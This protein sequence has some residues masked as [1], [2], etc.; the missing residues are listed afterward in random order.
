[1]AISIPMRN[2]ISFQA[3]A[4][5]V[6]ITFVGFAST[7]AVIVEGL[8]KMGAS[9]AEASSGLMAV[10]IAMGL[11]GLI[12]SLLTKMPISVAWSTPGAAL[13][14]SSSALPDGFGGAVGAFM[15]TGALIILA[16]LFKPLGRAVAAIPHPLGNAMLAGVLFGLCLAP[17]KAVAAFPL[18][19]LAI[20]VVWVAVAR[21]KRI[22][23]VPAAV[24]VTVA[25][26]VLNAH[27]GTTG[28]AEFHLASLWP[29]PVV[30]TPSF[31]LA[32]IVGIAIP[33]FLVTMASQNIPG[34]AVL[35]VNGYKP[36]PGKMFAATGILSLLAA[37]FGSHA[38]NLAAI[39]AAL[40]A[41]PDAHPDP[42][43]RYWATATSGALYILVGLMAGAATAFIAA[44]PPL[45]VE[46]VAGLA[47]LGAFGSAVMGAVTAPADREAAVITFVVTAS[48]VGFLG[49]SGA[50]WG[51]I[52]GAVVMALFRWRRVR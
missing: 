36:D 4:T 33:L 1:L 28:A 27:D 11:G 44:S 21:I 22:L 47:L 29:A 3:V 51:L 10:S 7:F 38:V 14:A 26:V 31:S 13:L 32:G 46:A 17:V 18:Y 35:A 37:P 34:I 20:I 43:R 8:T 49:I 19:G 25:V 16:G 45:L 41:G 5:G 48:G 6:L 15:V 40:G 12:L 23:A 24:L 9:P 39:T 30:V 50:F 52:A 2:S 42:A